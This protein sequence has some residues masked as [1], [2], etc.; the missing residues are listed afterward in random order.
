MI[1]DSSCRL[2]EN[3]LTDRKLVGVKGIHGVKE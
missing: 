3:L 1:D 2:C